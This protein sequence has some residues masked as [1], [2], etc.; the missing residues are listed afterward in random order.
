MKAIKDMIRTVP[1]FPKKGIQFRDITTL[2]SDP[3]GLRL[4]I[5][6]FCE[7]Y[8]DRGI[9][10]VVGIEARGFILGSAVAYKLGVGFV[11]VRKKGKLPGN[12]E[13]FEYDLEYGT[14]TVE[15]HSDALHKGTKVL[16]IDDLL[17]TGGTCL[18]AAQLVEKV[19]GVVEEIAFIVDLPDLKGRDRL[20]KRGYR[21]FALCKFEGD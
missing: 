2:L 14:D 8:K 6:T 12:V 3:D 11:P 18:A 1:D 5:D 17:A 15:I 4:T 13:R 21:I 7:R 10:A 19:G 20:L 16:L 9:E